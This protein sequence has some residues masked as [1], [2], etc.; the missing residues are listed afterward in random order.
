M[1]KFMFEIP[2]RNVHFQIETKL[3]VTDTMHDYN[4]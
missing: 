4:R 2:L 3:I 1:T